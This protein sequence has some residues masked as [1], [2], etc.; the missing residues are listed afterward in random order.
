MPSI[1]S[2]LDNKYSYVRRNAVLALYTIY[3]NF[4][5]LKRR[6]VLHVQFQLVAQFYNMIFR[7]IL[8]MIQSMLVF[9]SNYKTRHWHLNISVSGTRCPW[10]D[11]GV[12]GGRTR[13]L[14]QTKCIYH[15]DTHWPTT[16]FGLPSVLYWRDWNFRFVRNLSIFCQLLKLFFYF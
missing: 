13:S 4:E 12:S 8:T 6:G 7:L 16:S 9:S 3:R 15:A 11:P 1:R 5:V 10:A 2:C 14:L